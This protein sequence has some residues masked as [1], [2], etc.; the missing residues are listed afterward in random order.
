MTL[1]GAATGRTGALR[2]DRDVR[3]RRARRRTAHPRGHARRPRRQVDPVHDALHDRERPA[4]R[5]LALRRDERLPRC[6]DDARL[7]RRKRNGD[8]HGAVRQ[9]RPTISSCVSTRARP[10]SSAAASRP[11]RSCTTSPATGRWPA[12]G[13]LLLLAA[14]DRHLANPTGDPTVVPA[15]Y[16]NG[17]WRPIPVVPTPG[18]PAARLERRRILR[19][20]RDPRPDEAPHRVH[21][22]PRPLPAAAA[23]RR[24]R[25]RR[26]DGLTLRWA[27]GIDTTGPIVADPALRRRCL[28]PDLRLD[29]VRDEDGTRSPPA[30]R[31]A[32]RSP[33]P[34]S[35]GTSAPRRRRCARCRRS[36]A[37]PSPR[38]RRRWRAAGFAARHGHARAVRRAGGHG[39]RRRPAS[40]CSSSASAV[41]LTVSA[42]PGAG[43]AVRLRA[44]SPTFFRPAARR[45]IPRRSLSPARHRV[46]T[47][48]DSDGHRLASWQRKLHAGVNTRGSASRRF[49]R[50]R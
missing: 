44:L 9:A 17:A 40:R 48:L 20:R 45:T 43:G 41:D 46:V 3:H 36:R 42:G 47:L 12:R 35:P 27:P 29:A 19:P 25:R 14:R 5:G 34:I 50:R 7:D 49:R 6:P 1:D 15:T 18:T 38:R 32:S 10:P 30:T 37:G 11:A 24:E 23:A 28:V 26:G 33:R 39:D 21:A 8:D 22:A 31:A 4:A 13:A 16:E 2:L